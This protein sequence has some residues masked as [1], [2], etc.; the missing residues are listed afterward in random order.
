MTDEEYMQLALDLASATVGQTSPNPAVGAIVVKNGRVVGM[1]AHLQSGQA[2]AEVIALEMA[3]KEAEGADVYVTLE[4]C[5]HYGKTPPCAELLIQKKVKR[6]VIATKDPNE[7]VS[8]SGIVILERA[9]IEVVIGVLQEKA[10][11]LNRR[12]FHYIQTRQPYVTLK[13]AASL[14]GKTATRTGESKWITGEAARLRGHD[15][16]HMHDAILVGVDTVIADDPS[17]TVRR[18][19]GG[20][21][22]IR[23][24]LDR[25]LRIPLSAQMIEDKKAPVWVICT[26]EADRE[27]R[28]QLEQKGVQIFPLKTRTIDVR[29]VLSLLGEKEITSL[30]V[31]GGATV[32]A[33]FIEK[34][35]F[36]E[37]V[38]FIAPKIIGGIQA[39]SVIGGE[40]IASMKEITELDIVSLERVGGDIQIVAVPKKKGR[41]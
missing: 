25:H 8:G 21:H 32:H 1:G 39:P 36:Q 5:S 7:Q 38:C 34:H 10:E 23:V 33:S 2:H 16:R 30:Y 12:F 13:T 29:D 4:P 11:W 41:T 27:K 20:K 31:E 3:G 28:Q 19:N 6:V 35:L 37:I 17:L 26:D 24:V 40:G 14:D 18:P 9:G 15:F 22:P